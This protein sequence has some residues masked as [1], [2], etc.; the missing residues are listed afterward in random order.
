MQGTVSGPMPMYAMGWNKWTN[1]LSEAK[2]YTDLKAANRV[3]KGH[4][5][6]GFKCELLHATLSVED[7]N[8]LLEKALDLD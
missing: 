4:A 6:G 5:P 3:A 2:L 7:T 1:S 8:D